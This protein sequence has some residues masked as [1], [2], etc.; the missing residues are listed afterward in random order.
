ML[1]LRFYVSLD[2]VFFAWQII[3]ASLN[4][5]SLWIL[6]FERG[7]EFGQ[8]CGVEMTTFPASLSIHHKTP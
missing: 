7:L 4:F 5:P 3:T 8:C 2:R 6:F 1:Y